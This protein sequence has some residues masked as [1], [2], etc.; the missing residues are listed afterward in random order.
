MRVLAVDLGAARIGVAIGEL[1]FKIASP[2][3]ALAASGT[4]QRDAEAIV[5]LAKTEAAHCVVV[6]LPLGA[7]GDET[8]MS[9]VCRQLG[10]KI[11]AMGWRVA[12]VNEAM[13]SVEA[14]QVLRES[15]RTAAARRK[16]RDG[17]AACRI[18]D[19]FFHEVE[20]S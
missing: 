16:V 7:S 13:T 6:G 1:E 17:E 2:K 11:E 20:G 9:R 12:Y 5:Q 18:L 8:R 14:E 10:E 3:P 15:D 19:R 4:L